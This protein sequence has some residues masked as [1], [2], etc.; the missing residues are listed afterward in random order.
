MRLLI[1]DHG[2]PVDSAVFALYAEAVRHFPDAVTLIEWD[3]RLPPFP[4]LL[5]E[6][7]AADR[8]RARV[9]AEVPHVAAA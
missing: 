7:H 2:S 4:E 3:S 6:A 1:D 9:F 5:R 8:R